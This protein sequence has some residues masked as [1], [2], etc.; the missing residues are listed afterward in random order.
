MRITIRPPVRA[1]FFTAQFSGLFKLHER[2]LL[3]EREVAD[4]GRS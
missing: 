1:A 2:L 3:E 4:A